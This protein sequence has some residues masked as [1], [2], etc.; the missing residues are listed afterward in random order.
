MKFATVAAVIAV[1]SIT[2]GFVSPHLAMV[3]MPDGE[4]R[5]GLAY[6]FFFGIPAE[7]LAFLPWNDGSAMFAVI[8]LYIVQ[9]E[10]L[11]TVMAGAVWL[12]RWTFGGQHTRG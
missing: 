12:V 11:F 5:H 4:P 6:Q 7:F 10:I 2:L 9:Y 8:G 1:L 3:L